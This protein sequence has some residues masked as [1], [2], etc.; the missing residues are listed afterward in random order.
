[1]SENPRIAALAADADFV[2]L[3][4]AL[5]EPQSALT[6]EAE[7]ALAAGARVDAVALIDFADG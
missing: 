2:L 4:A 5:G 1:M 3:V 7:S 6:L